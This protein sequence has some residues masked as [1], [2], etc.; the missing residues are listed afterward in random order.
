MVNSFVAQTK[1]LMVL[2]YVVVITAHSLNL[3]V[4][5]V[6]I[7]R[8][9]NCEWAV[10]HNDGVEPKANP[11]FVRSFVCSCA[12]LCDYLMTVC[13]CVIL[14]CTAL[15]CSPLLCYVE[16]VFK[17]CERCCRSII[18]HNFSLSAILFISSE[19]EYSV[20]FLLLLFF[21]F[22][23]EPKTHTHT[24]AHRVGRTKKSH[25]QKYGTIKIRSIQIH[26]NAWCGCWRWWWR[27]AYECIRSH[28][29]SLYGCLCRSIPHSMR[30]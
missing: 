27:W 26:F 7:D 3:S 11:M 2:K 9:S 10:Q 5:R 18:Y 8:R 25:R 24:H 20:F 15:H 12:V 22:T 28:T 19:I 29:L 4:N 30:C 17:V 23:L 1:I 6:L 21:L 16:C 13:A 14:R